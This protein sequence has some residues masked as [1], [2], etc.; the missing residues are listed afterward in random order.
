MPPQH[1]E[2]EKKEEDK[3]EE[4]LEACNSPKIEQPEEYGH[5]EE[6]EKKTAEGE[7]NPKEHT[8]S[9]FP[10]KETMFIQDFDEEEGRTKQEALGDK[11]MEIQ[12]THEEEGGHESPRG[13]SW[14]PEWLE[15][16]L[17]K[18]TPTSKD[19]R[20]RLEKILALAQIS[21]KKEKNPKV[22]SQL[23]MDASGSRTVQ[24]TT[25]VMGEGVTYNVS[26]LYLGMSTR[27]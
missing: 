10:Q 23:T 18:K 21:T 17:E 9:E 12:H 2:E 13:E 25:L 4:E 7:D 16:Q 27:E 11:V 22:R 5:D 15:K 20:E 6:E 3:F 26:T 1:E 14:M 24:I 19:P 8:T